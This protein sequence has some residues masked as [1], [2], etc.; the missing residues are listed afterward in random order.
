MHVLLGAAAVV[1]LFA[2]TTAPEAARV[3]PAPKPMMAAGVEIARSP[4]DAL[5]ARLARQRRAVAELEAALAERLLVL[6]LRGETD[7]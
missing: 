2:L 6:W 3:C 5:D 7:A 1:A 4:S